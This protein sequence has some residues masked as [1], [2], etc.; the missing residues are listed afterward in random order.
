MTISEQTLSIGQLAGQAGVHVET[1]R[2]YQRCGLLF[3]PARNP[4]EIRRYGPRDLDRLMFIRTAKL[5]GFSL[6]EI[7]QLLA[8]EDGSHCEETAALAEKKLAQI[9]RQQKALVRMEQ[10]L[11]QLLEQCRHSDGT[12]TCPLI[13][14]LNGHS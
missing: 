2:Y 6:G 4:G 13:E 5:L 3:E 1:I 12:V 9:N 11:T 8:L 14:S 7:A 10:A